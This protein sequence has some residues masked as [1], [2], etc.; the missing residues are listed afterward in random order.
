MNPNGMHVMQQEKTFT[1]ESETKLTSTQ[2]HEIDAT[3]EIVSTTLFYRDGRQVQE[4]ETDAARMV[5]S[6]GQV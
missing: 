2:N 3:E 5:L 4:V 6:C 1:T